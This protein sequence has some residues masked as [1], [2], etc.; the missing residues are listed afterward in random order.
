MFKALIR[1]QLASVMASLMRSSKGNEKRSGGSVNLILPRSIG[2]C[3][4]V[5]TPVQQLESWI[6]AGL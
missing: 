5:P 1:V 4:I 3:A 6:Q 2:D